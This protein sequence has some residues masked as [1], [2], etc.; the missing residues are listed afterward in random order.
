MARGSWLEC[1]QRVDDDVLNATAHFQITNSYFVRLL[2]AIIS[3]WLAHITTGTK[4]LVAHG[5][6]LVIAMGTKVVYADFWRQPRRLCECAP[7]SYSIHS[8]SNSS[9]PNDMQACL[10]E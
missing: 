5:M 7:S 2:F 8:S 3:H 10:H 4:N 6:F 1:T 9:L